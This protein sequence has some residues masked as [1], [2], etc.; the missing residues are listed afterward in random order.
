M[1]A[2]SIALCTTGLLAA[3]YIPPQITIPAGIAV[4][5]G[6]GI[7]YA[8]REDKSTIQH[9]E[10]SEIPLLVQLRGAIKNHPIVTIAFGTA[11]SIGFAG[12]V[13]RR[14]DLE[15]ERKMKE[16]SVPT[17]EPV[18]IYQPGAKLP[19]GSGILNAPVLPDDTVTD[20]TLVCDSENNMFVHPDSQP[21]SSKD[22]IG[23]TNCPTTTMKVQSKFSD[24]TFDIQVPNR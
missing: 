10:N 3:N 17:F 12:G 18:Q 13:A 19:N 11:L 16:Q 1:I 24:I 6:M 4:A 20:R 14:S 9:K 15:T 2:K 23:I 8:L 7:E 5:T 21:V 22:L